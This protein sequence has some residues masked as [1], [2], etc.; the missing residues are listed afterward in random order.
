MRVS[1]RTVA[2]ACASVCALSGCTAPAPRS[3]DARDVDAALSAFIDSIRA[4]DNHTHINIVAAVDT[5]YD[6]LPLDGIPFELPAPLRADSP[7]FRAAF[8]ALY[9]DSSADTSAAHAAARH[10]TMQRIAKAKGD[11]FPAW[12]LDQIGTDVAL[13]NRIAMGP[14]L[15]SPRFRWVS[16]ADA[17]MLPLPTTAEA[18]TSPDRLKLYPLEEKLLRRYLTDRQLA[19]IPR[20]LDAYQRMV[21]T[22]TL[23]AQRNGGCVAVKFEAGYLRSLDFADVPLRTAS[24]IYSKYAAGGVPSHVEYKALQDYL[25]RYIARE[26]G[27]LGMAVHVHAFEGFGNAYNVAGS[28]PLLLEGAFNDTTLHATNFVILHG[29]GVYASHTGAMLWKPNVYTDLSTIAIAYSTEQLA[30]VLRSWLSQYP[31]KV[32]FGTDA[33]AFGPDAGWELLAWSGTRSVRTALA[34]ALTDMVRSG[35]VTPARAREIATM[36]MRTNASRLY[37]LGLK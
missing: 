4:V 26:A 24:A 2:I 33:F 3:T 25:F 21:V 34:T 13:A 9:A 23:E 28:D 16:Y 11:S 19:A 10:S 32:L 29:G 27:R 36:V 12:A 22:P 30:V 18:A 20:T 1:H 15:A 8:A 5:E 14:G 31:E 35:D 7:R 37:G 6:A 17:L